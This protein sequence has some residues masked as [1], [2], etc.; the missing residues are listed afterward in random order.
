[1]FS[2]TERTNRKLS[3]L[4]AP[5]LGGLNVEDAIS[6][7]LATVKGERITAE[8]IPAAVAKGDDDVSRWS[9]FQKGLL[10]FYFPFSSLLLLFLFCSKFKSQTY[11]NE[12]EVSLEF[13][14]LV[15]KQKSIG[16]SNFRITNL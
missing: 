11:R 16:I 4:N 1:M 8:M 2:D 3:V 5:V 15:S 9:C 13:G 10:Y 14:I 7:S 6:A 12:C